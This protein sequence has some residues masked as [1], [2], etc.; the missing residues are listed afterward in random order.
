LPLAPDVIVSQLALLL[1]DHGQPAGAVTVTD[2]EP[3]AVVTDWVFG[4]IV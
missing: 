3:P 4:E 1:A 2:P